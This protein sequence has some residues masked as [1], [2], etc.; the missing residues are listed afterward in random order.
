MV[1]WRRRRALESDRLRFLRGRR[2]CTQTDADRAEIARR[3]TVVS[4]MAPRAAAAVPLTGILIGVQG[5]ARPIDPITAW[6]SMTRPHPLL[7]PADVLGRATRSW[8]GSRE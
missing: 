3:A 8:V 5:L 2:G 4:R 6:Q 7:E 1:R